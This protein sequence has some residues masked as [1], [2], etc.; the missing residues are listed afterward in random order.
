MISAKDL[1]KNGFALIPI[2]LGKKGPISPKWN[3]PEKAITDPNEARLLEGLNIGVA[4]KYC[5]PTPTCAIDIDNYPAAKEWLKE[6]E[7]DLT[8]LLSDHDAVVISSGRS[9]STKLLYRL[10]PG[11]TG[12]ESQTILNDREGCILEFRCSTRDGLTVQD[13]LPPSRHPQGT[14]YR[15][16]GNGN[17]ISPP[18]IP[19]TVLKLWMG[20]TEQDIKARLLVRIDRGGSNTPQLAETPRQI[21][22]VRHALSQI[23][24]DCSYET[25]R[26]VI[27]ALRSTGWNCA[28]QLAYEWSK[29]ALDRF[30][31]VAFSKVNTSYKPN[32]PTPI[33]LGT[34]FHHAK[35]GLKNG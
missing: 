10:P 9:Q 26:D 27:W 14:Q 33:T 22:E 24:A 23:D 18:E 17:P 32:H 34:L 4:H 30:N 21:A 12:I 20:L 35:K 19:S 28:E 3:H 11:Y 16:S 25:W 13:V 6:R 1:L 31:E 8:Q 29:S 2:P 15:F 5:R 7:I